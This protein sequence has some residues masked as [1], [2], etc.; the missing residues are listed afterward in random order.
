ML[1][2]KKSKKEETNIMNNERE[3]IRY[4]NNNDDIFIQLI[5]KFEDNFSKIPDYI[6]YH[7]GLNFSILYSEF[8][9]FCIKSNFKSSINDIINFLS[10]KRDEINSIYSYKDIADIINKSL[11]LNYRSK[12]D[13]YVMSLEKKDF[14]EYNIKDENFICRKGSIKDFNKLKGLQKKYHLEEVYDNDSSYPYEAEMINFKKI[15]SNRLNYIVFYKNKPV[16]K[17]SVNSESLNSFQIGGVY[18]LKKF[19]G[20]GLSKF[21]LSNLLKEAFNIKKKVL[22]YVK[23]ENI[24]AISVY[25]HLGFKIINTTSMVYY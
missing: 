6:K 2:L 9:N 16:S 21:C 24:P 18:T 10:S 13:Y 5:D 17:C 19:R 14:R 4:F 22:L 11:N 20:L 25:R 8:G 23:Q 3:I 1:F 15:L 7:F 12:I